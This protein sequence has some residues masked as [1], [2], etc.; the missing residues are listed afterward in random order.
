LL[1]SGKER[2][3]TILLKNRIL[4]KAALMGVRAGPMI[5]RPREDGIETDEA[6]RKVSK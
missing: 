6:V 2:L 5:D 3:G 1:T 4:P